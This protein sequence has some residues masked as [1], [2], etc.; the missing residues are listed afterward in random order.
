MLLN[1][2]L[3]HRFGWQFP[4]LNHLRAGWWLLPEALAG[5]AVVSVLAAWEPL[6]RG[7]GIPEAMEAVLVR[8]SRI[9]VRPA[10]AKPLASVIAIGTG[11]PFGA[12][13]PIILT[14]SALGSLLGQAVK[15]S[16]AERKV[17][18][19]AGAAAGMSAIFG[20]PIGA[21][22]LAIELLLFEFSPR[23]LVP[24]VVASVFADGVHVLL[25]GQGPL[26]PV[27]PNDFSGLAELPLY[28]VLGLVCGILGIV[29][30]R[31]AFGLEDF[32]TSL[33]VSRFWHPIIGAGVVALIGLAV[34][35]ALGVGYDVIGDTLGGRL[36]VAT[37]AAVFIAKLAAWCIAIG[38]GSSGSSLAPLLLV[39]ASAGAL[40]GTAVSTVFPGAA[41]S[42]GAF[43]VVG[44]AATF[45][46]ASGAPFTSMVLA[47]E[48]TRDY[49]IILPL[50]FATVIAHLLAR[51]LH[52]ET[53]MTEKLTR[54]GIRV[55]Q[56]YEVDRQRITPVSD[57]MGPAADT[58]EQDMTVAELTA[59]MRRDGR[60]AVV[61]VD[62]D[63]KVVGIVTEGDIVRHP[64]QDAATAA[65]IASGDVVSVTP[66]TTVFEASQC[67]LHEGVRQLPVMEDGQ[68]RGM[69]SRLDSLRFSELEANE[70]QEQPGWQWSPR[71]LSVLR[72]HGG[73]ADDMA[74]GDGRLSVTPSAVPGA[75][76]ADEQG[77]T[78]GPKGEEDGTR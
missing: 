78:A 2:S 75:D 21:V 56:R 71:W 66:T 32:F 53:L 62:D 17:L 44:M 49:N 69:F 47:F 48:I 13:G 8:Q 54:R 76:I 43:A 40:V 60:H 77:G 16:P 36:A 24:I 9:G 27:P 10:V 6:I 14:G 52:P 70:D 30:T 1:L 59:T 37:L 50:M 11:A 68:L 19:A 28:V 33:P 46:A 35:R 38:S 31:G 12:E 45:G 39:G 4:P 22:L 61:V 67:L 7:H 73:A 3:Q 64:D 74:K 20:A 5:G 58:V 25:I 41:I 26:F 57:V 65:S 63:G 72:R 42:P 18:L 15:V 55:S 51:S 29:I 23:V 34:P